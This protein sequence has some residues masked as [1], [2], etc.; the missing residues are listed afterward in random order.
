M[1]LRSQIANRPSRMSFPP[2]RANT[3][4]DAAGQDDRITAIFTIHPRAGP[5]LEALNEVFQLPGQLIA[6]DLAIEME[7]LKVAAK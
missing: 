5:L 4:K 6:V 3:L 2:V 1:A 7:H